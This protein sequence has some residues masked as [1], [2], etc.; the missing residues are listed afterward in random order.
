MLHKFATHADRNFIS[1]RTQHKIARMVQFKNNGQKKKIHLLV[2][3]LVP[4][5]Q[6]KKKDFFK[7]FEYFIYFCFYCFVI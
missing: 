1:K 3:I 7:K 6:L 5:L 4:E 2:K